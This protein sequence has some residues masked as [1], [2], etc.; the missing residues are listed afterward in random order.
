MSAKITYL[1]TGVSI[2]SVSTN[3]LIVS[4]LPNGYANVSSGILNTTT[5][6]PLTSLDTSVQNAINITIPSM[7]SNITMLQSNVTS[8]Q[9]DVTTLQAYSPPVGSL[10]Q[11]AGSTAPAGWL[12][13]QGQLLTISSYPSLFNVIGNVYGGNGVTQFALPDLRGRVAIGSGGSYSIGSSGGSETC[14]LTVN[15]MPAHTHTGTI[16]GVSNHTHTY[17]DAYFAEN[18]GGAGPKVFGTSSSSDADNNFYYRTQSGSYSTNPND[19]S[20][21]LISGSG[22]AHTHTMSNSSTG[23]GASFSIVQPYLTVSY[24]IKY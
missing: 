24:I 16:D 11:Y 14:T 17:Q 8:L 9:T 3:E 12:L 13:C 5:I 19:S 22:G 6:I 7:Q 18:T 1:N 10:F 2:S 23:G 15:E 21:Q 4:S 20:T